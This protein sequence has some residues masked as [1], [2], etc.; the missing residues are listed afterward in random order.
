MLLDMRREQIAIL[1][2]AIRFKRGVGQCGE[3]AK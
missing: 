1:Q 2:L 3:G